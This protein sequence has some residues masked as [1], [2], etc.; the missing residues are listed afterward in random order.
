[1]P[2]TDLHPTT[3][4][5]RNKWADDRKTIWGDSFNWSWVRPW[6]QL[7]GI[8]IHHSVTKHD[9]TADDIAL[10]HKARG[11]AG[12]GYHFVIT[13]DGVVHYV[14][15]I[16]TAR[17][18]VLN[19]NEKFLGIVLVGD[20][21]KHLPSDDQILSAH[22]LVKFFLTETP[23]IP[24]LNNWDQLGG[25][26]DQQATACPGTSWKGSADSM[27]ERIVNRIPYTPEPDP[28]P[29]VDPCKGYIEEIA[30]LKKEI[31][32]H[33][34]PIVTPEPP[35]GGYEVLTV[36]NFDKDGNLIGTKKVVRPIK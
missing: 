15:D 31:D 10:L 2:R 8:L 7:E 6:S 13:K 11:W 14:G 29:P 27:H 3:L 19:K 22:D 36:E 21:T 24:T 18:H 28:V 35:V 5:A 16:S 9:A 33:E 34:C 26:K 4:I 20:F 1:M 17:A 23:S 32:D 25:H 30:S 12:I